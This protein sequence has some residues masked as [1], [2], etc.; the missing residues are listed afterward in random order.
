MGKLYFKIKNIFS[1]LI[2]EPLKEARLNFIEIYNKDN[3]KGIALLISFILLAIALFSISFTIYKSEVITYKI[4]KTSTF[5]INSGASSEETTKTITDILS[6]FVWPIFEDYIGNTADPTGK[7][8]CIKGENLICTFNNNDSEIR[9]AKSDTKLTSA[10]KFSNDLLLL[11]G[12][13]FVLLCII[14]GFNYITNDNREEIKSL[15][16]RLV[17]SL[18]LLI[19]TPYLLSFSI[20]GINLLTNAIL[21]N[22]SIS[23]SLNEVVKSIIDGYYNNPATKALMNGNILEFFLQG[24]A[25]SQI[26]TFL[27]LTIPFGLVIILLIYICFQFIIRFLNLYFLTA[28]YPFTVVFCAHSKTQHIVSSYFKQW[29]TFII[30]QPVFILGF[31]VVI[32]MLNQL[33]EKGE[34]SLQYLIIFLG[35]LLF[36]ASINIFSARIWG[37]VYT[38]IAQNMTAAIGTHGIISS[39]KNPLDKINSR[40][41]NKSNGFNVLNIEKASP[42]ISFGN[43]SDDTNIKNLKSNSDPVYKDNRS[44]LIKI[45]DGAGYDVQSNKDGT[46][47]ISGIFFTN[48]ENASVISPLY[49]SRE[50]ALNDGVLPKNIKP[51]DMNKL[52]ILDS[53]NGK[54]MK[55]YNN[56]VNTIAASSGIKAPNINIGQNSLDTKIIKSMNISKNE[57]FGKNI[58]GI[59]VKNDLKNGDRQNS[60]DNRVKIFAYKE[61]I[62]NQ[63][64]GTS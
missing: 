59:G 8:A 50:D 21:T 62:N 23:S 6:E 55:K 34:N 7:S 37:D 48:K 47:N 28:V 22:S 30:Q 61:V 24:G 12:P 25:V 11:I 56:Q 52:N 9:F 18:V 2:S 38:T 13:I 53:S 1:I 32:D 60:N 35:I 57:N 44:S 31:K 51:I 41:S 40:D 29:T 27:I 42:N 46:A 17:L 14:Q 16:K 39:V 10:Q 5:I 43:K 63:I 19:I 20:V 3:L 58:Q 33:K 45:L 4:E 49:I 26:I 36:L 54:E 15:L 64:N